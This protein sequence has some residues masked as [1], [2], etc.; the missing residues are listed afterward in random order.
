MTFSPGS[1]FVHSEISFRPDVYSETLFFDV[2]DLSNGIED[3][4][5]LESSLGKTSLLIDTRQI[6]VSGKLCKPQE[7]H[8]LNIVSSGIT[9]VSLLY[10]EYREKD[11][12]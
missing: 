3:I 8:Y 5:R 12:V 4:I 10:V 9:L 1:I 7:P 6:Y 11:V 2:F